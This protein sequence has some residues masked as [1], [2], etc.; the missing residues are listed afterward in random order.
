MLDSSPAATPCTSDKQLA[1]YCTSDDGYLIPSVIA[2]YAIR[3]FH[4]NASYFIF[5]DFSETDQ[6]LALFE[7]FRITYLPLGEEARIFQD[8]ISTLTEKTRRPAQNFWKLI[9][10]RALRQKGFDYSCCIDGDVLCVNPVDL[11]QPFSADW[12]LAAV[13]KKD[14]LI[15]GGVLFYNHDYLDK[16]DFAG[17]VTT[18]YRQDKHCRHAVCQGFCRER[19]PDDLLEKALIEHQIPWKVLPTQYNHLLPYPQSLYEKKNVTTLT[20]V[21]ECSFLHLQLKPW[22]NASTTPSLYPMLQQA[23]LLWKEVA[24]E[25]LPLVRPFLKQ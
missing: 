23:F 4:A 15:N 12:P 5:G 10:Y 20:S 2:L 7:R 18:L 17:K 19:S 3:R 22:L 25:V 11:T 1:F 14:G 6:A 8:V 21:E 24:E 9:A 13:V 16:I